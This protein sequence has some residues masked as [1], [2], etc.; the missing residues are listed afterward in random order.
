MDLQSWLVLCAIALSGSV[1]AENLARGRPYDLRPKPNYALCADAGDV[2]QL[3]DGFAAKEGSFWTSKSTV[4]W[5]CESA[6]VSVTVDLGAVR[7]I[8]G[9]SWNTA[10]GRAGVK[11]PNDVNVFVSDDRREW[12]FVA[13]IWGLANRRVG[14][15]PDGRYAIARAEATGLPCRGRY[16]RFVAHQQ[17]YCF[18]DEVEVLSGNVSSGDGWK[19]NCPPAENPERYGVSVNLCRKVLTHDAKRLGVFGTFERRIAADTFPDGAPTVLPLTS[20]HAEIWAQ[21][22]ARLRAAGF[23]HPALWTNCRWDN[24]DPLAVPPADSVGAE[25]VEVEMMRGEVRAATVNL[26]NPTSRAMTWTMTSEG[27]PGAAGVDLR[28]VVMTATAGGLC[29]SGALLP[30]TNGWVRL[31]V[32][33]GASRQVWISFRRPRLPG[34]VY[35]GRLVARAEGRAPLERGLRLRL[36]DLDFPSRPTLHVGGWDYVERGNAYYRSPKNLQGKL[37]EMR[38]IFTDS[39]WAN[40][41]VAPLGAKFDGDGR[42]VNADQLDYRVWDAWTALWP[43]ARVFCVFYSGKDRFNGEKTGTERFNR[44]VGEYFAA[45]RHRLKATHPSADFL[46]HTVDEPRNAADVKTRIAWDRAVKAGAPEIRLY[47]NP[48]FADPTKAEPEMYKLCDVIC[49]NVPIMNEGKS[50]PFY[51]DLQQKGCELWFYGCVGPSREFDPVGYYRAYEWLAFQMDAKACFWWAFGCG[52]GIGDSWRAFNQTG[53]EYSPFFVSPTDATSA[54]QSEGLREGVE[55][56]EYLLLLRKMAETAAPGPVKDEALRILEEAP[57]RVLGQAAEGCERF[58][59]NLSR[60]WTSE[61][62]RTVIDQ[63]RLRILRC[64]S[65]LR[66]S[67]G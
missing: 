61:T 11:F 54:K 36:H 5:R 40:A 47:N 42:L 38:E 13:D 58:R 4:G 56:Y 7:D 20:V 26:L 16:V 10:A 64:L 48:I 51:R 44:M 12:R 9:F 46:L 23:D 24:L 31:T 22:V 19:A 43:D 18:V 67:Q 33:A 3:T 27:F 62:D 59:I 50:A 32:P 6:P 8:G 21:N 45:W 63:E 1:C 15:P 39:P 35:D 60:E 37:R 52:G 14:M 30:G 66:A 65:K 17:P 28:E 34:G 2:T 53:V 41:D 57:Q 49:P 25:P 55:D 29:V